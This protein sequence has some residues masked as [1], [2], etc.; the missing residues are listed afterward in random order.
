MRLAKEKKRLEALNKDLGKRANRNFNS[1]LS[2]R[3]IVEELDAAIQRLPEPPSAFGDGPDERVGWI[4]REHDAWKK[5]TKRNLRFTQHVQARLEETT[6]MGEELID[7]RD[8]IIAHLEADLAHEREKVTLLDASFDIKPF[9]IKQRLVVAEA[10]LA[11]L[12]ERAERV[13]EGEDWDLV[14]F[15]LRKTIPVHAPMCLKNVAFK[16][17]ICTCG[18]EKKD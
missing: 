12:R 15:I 14:E 3:Q 13:Q 10:N 11:A 17:C 6:K 9:D 1:W 7:E 16:D 8:R 4:L 5:A 18:A 2:A